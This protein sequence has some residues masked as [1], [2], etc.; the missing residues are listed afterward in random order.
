MVPLEQLVLSLTK[1]EARN[2]KLLAQRTRTKAQRKDLLL[3]DALRKEKEDFSEEKFLRRAYPEGDKNNYYRLR[4]RLLE[5]LLKSQLNLHFR[6]K[7]AVQA[8]NYLTLA[9]IFFSKSE[10]HI[11]HFLLKKAEKKAR[12]NEDFELLELVYSFFIRLS[13]EIVTINPKQYID[14]RQ[15]NYELLRRFRE[16]DDILATVNYNLK[17]SQ[18]Y[19]EPDAESVNLTRQIIEKLSDLPRVAQSIKFKLKIY[20]AISKLLL[21]TKDYETLSKF[22]VETFEQFESEKRFSRFNHEDK[23]T[24]LTFIVNALFKQSRYSES[25]KYAQTLGGEIERHNRMFYDKYII[26]YYNSLIINYSELDLDKAIELGERLIKESTLKRYSFYEVIIHMN[27]AI[28][29]FKKQNYKTAIREL[30][31]SHA[32]ENYKSASEALKH[33]IAMAELIIRF[34]MEDTEVWERRHRQIK[35]EFAAT[36]NSREKDQAFVALLGKLNKYRIVQPEK[37]RERINE[38]L[39]TYNDDPGESEVINYANWLRGSSDKV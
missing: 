36:I 10:F 35:K 32:H 33:S 7:E 30:I 11:A 37:A 39:E 31:K 2:Y 28:F 4:N 3:F 34:E 18:N 27:L 25:L 29:H 1:E 5:D 14:K 9:Q 19:D 8:T 12:E 13:V 17:I 38:F 26:F 16:I 21:Q 24:M 20:H 6:D 22:S 23:L 15:E